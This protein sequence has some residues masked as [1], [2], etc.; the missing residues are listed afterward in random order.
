[1]CHDI[2]YRI[3]YTTPPLQETKEAFTRRMEKV[4]TTNFTICPLHL[5]PLGKLKDE[6][7]MYHE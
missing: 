3:I 6:Q 1:M 4:H 2:N 7:S 5:I